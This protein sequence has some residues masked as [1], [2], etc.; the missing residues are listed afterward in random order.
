MS[1]NK[2]IVVRRRKIC[3]PYGKNK[4]ALCIYKKIFSG[5]AA[6]SLQ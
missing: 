1:E 3:V 6:M 5:E 4:D 2:N